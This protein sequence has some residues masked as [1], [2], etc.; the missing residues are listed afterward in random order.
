MNVSISYLL[1]TSEIFSSWRCLLTDWITER[2]KSKGSEIM[3]N[4]IARLR[5]RL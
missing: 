5:N 1:T 2:L 3:M 4:Y